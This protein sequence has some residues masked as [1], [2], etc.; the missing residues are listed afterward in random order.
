MED[1]ELS[2]SKEELLLY[3]TRVTLFLVGAALLLQLT[4]L[5]WLLCSP[6]T[7]PDFAG[8]IFVFGTGETDIAL[9]LICI[10]ED[11]LYAAGLFAV[12]LLAERTVAS[13]VARETYS[14]ASRQ[15]KGP[16]VRLQLHRKERKMLRA[17]AIIL[18]LLEPFCCGFK[19][20]L[21]I[22]LECGGVT[23]HISAAAIVAALILLIMVRE[24]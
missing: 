20:L 13:L 9:R 10:T 12:I 14:G 17:A 8:V 7:I 22:L 2:R 23:L 6:E 4:F 3:L 24:K 11:T 19:A 16:S 1:E 18:L 5:V 15:K 21:A